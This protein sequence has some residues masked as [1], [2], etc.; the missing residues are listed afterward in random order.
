MVRALTLVNNKE[1]FMDKIRFEKCEKVVNQGVL[2]NDLRLVYSPMKQDVKQACL[3]LYVNVGGY[4]RT[5]TIDKVRIPQGT[6]GLLLEA[7][8][9]KHPASCDVLFNQADVKLTTEVYESYL[10]IKVTCPKEK[11]SDLINPLLNLV[12]TFSA[13]NE[14]VEALKAP[15]IEKIEKTDGEISNKL[16]KYIY[17][18]SGMLYNPYGLKENFNL[19]HMSTL[20]KFFN[21]F[22]TPSNLT[23]FV[24]NSSM[25]VEALESKVS[26]FKFEKKS[27]SNVI[28]V[29]NVKENYSSVKQN[30]GKSFKKG[31]FI[32]AIK[33]PLRK[34]MFEKY[35]EQMFFLYKLF[36]YILFSK[37]GKFNK[38]ITSNILSLGEGGIREG[39][40]DAFFYQEIETGNPEKLEEA[41]NRF[42][43]T[44]KHFSFFDFRNIRKEVL[45]KDR[46]IYHTDSDLYLEAL[47]NGYANDF[48]TPGI[49]EEASR[50]SSKKVENFFS[51][52]D[53]L[54]KVFLY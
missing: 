25:T 2:S 50:L 48:A 29:K 35:R 49:T 5:Y 9:N 26:K 20:K 21:E 1:F 12:N 27:P 33:F 44:N 16:R 23:L 40:E 19:I 17:F 10:L 41:L 36:P 39:G 30:H 34:T 45:I 37:N 6:P 15:Y 22:F 31:Q 24:V 54:P 13:T 32:F 28:N 38:E 14:E 51:T 42:I 8:I 11:V 18:E 46:R 3:G 52:L 4:G 47:A 7:L 43:S 53:T